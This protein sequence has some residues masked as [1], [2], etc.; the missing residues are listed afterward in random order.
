MS[1]R[2]IDFLSAMSIVAEVG[3]M[4]RF[5]HPRQLMSFLGLVPSEFSSGNSKQRGPITRTSNGRVRRLLIEVAW[6]YRFTANI[7]RDIRMRQ[8]GASL[9]RGHEH[10][11]RAV[12]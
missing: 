9:R 2:I 1:L 3:D 5:H 4:R 10:L 12:Q 8:E 11:E 6:S 7:S